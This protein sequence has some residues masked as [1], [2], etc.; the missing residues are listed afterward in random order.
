MPQ[1]SAAP[2]ESPSES[3]QGEAPEREAPEREAPSAAGALAHAIEEAAHLLPAQGPIGVFIHHNTLHAFQHLPFHEAV[4]AASAELETESYLSEADYRAAYARG[5]IDDSD[6]DAALAEHLAGDGATEDIDLA[7]PERELLHI[8]LRF[9]IP[10]ESAAGLRWQIDDLDALSHFRPEVDPPTRERLVQE[11]LRW[12]RR[13]EREGLSNLIDEPPHASLQSAPEAWVLRAMWTA[14]KS[15][16]SSRSSR[17]ALALADRVPS[18]RSHRDLLRAV[19]GADPASVV[20]ALLIRFCAAYLDQ[21][22]ASWAMP[23]REVGLYPAFRRTLRSGRWMM[24]QALEGVPA[25]LAEQARRGMS[26]SDVVLE[27]LELLGVSQANFTAYVARLLLEL[28]GWAGMIHRLET[29]PHEIEGGVAAPRLVDYL[30]ARLTCARVALAHHA[31]KELGYAGPLAE[32]PVFV[33]GL[34]LGERADRPARDE[35]A[36][37]LFN[38]L[39]LAGMSLADIEAIPPS[40][41][42]AIVDRLDDFDELTRRRVWHEAYEHHHRV[43]VLSAVRFAWKRARAAPPAPSRARYH[44]WFCIDDRE[45][46]MRRHLE[47]LGPL[48]ETTGLAGF[49]GVA[50][51]FRGLGSDRTASLCPVVVTPG[52]EIVEE[53]ELDHEQDQEA[54]EQRRELMARM[55]ASTRVGT[56][57]LFRSALLTPALGLLATFPMAMQVLFP[58]TTARLRAETTKWVNPTPRTR[59]RAIRDEQEDGSA[60][61]IGF[62]I[63]EAADRV[64]TTLENVGLV[65]DYPRVVALFGHGSTSVNNPHGSAYDCGACGGRHGS[66]NA[67]LFATLANDPRVREALREHGIDLPATTIFV[68]GYHDTATDAITLFDLD[69]VPE[70]HRADVAELRELLDVARR[71]NAHERCRRFASAPSDPTLDEALAHVEARAADLAQARPELGH[72]TNAVCLVG[73]REWSRGLFLDRR[74]FLVS[75]DPRIDLDG[76]ILERILAAVGPVG[77]GINLEYYFSCVDNDRYGSG[78][79][80]PHNLV[81]L[82]GVMDGPSSDLRTGLPRQMIE[83][84]E[85]VRLLTVVETTPERILEIAERQPE[86]RE[87]VINGWIQLAT[88]DPDSGLI[89]VFRPGFG[90][91]PLDAPERALPVV[92][93]SQAWYR[94]KHDFLPP[95]I[96]DPDARKSKRGTL[97]TKNKAPGGRAHAG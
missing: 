58:R 70:S 62:T 13:R 69:A 54:W 4:A 39:Q 97:R 1:Q 47:E 7:I 18:E 37:R 84:H 68:G 5:R 44:V 24:P 9:P 56:R 27:A 82:L 65:R 76:R 21:G 3:P 16:S 49:F 88:I 40:E 19:T 77:A 22:M 31:Q 94:G 34:D 53:P 73:R 45:E 81:G 80:L 17:S 91:T 78:T 23:E 64:R 79:K 25:L 6:L 51:D 55:T 96:V 29:H 71:R 14:C 36:F 8:A 30:A 66:P 41:R 52:H 12:L 61:P 95:A 26:A 33:R 87:L 2:S 59:L 48:V 75:Y 63:Q 50:I 43:E 32:L 83:I 46:S 86:V 35:A 10:V 85:P 15:V 20:N 89:H 28:P 92:P 90:F 38:V 93:S 74:A 42:Q 11:G 72:V 57:G 60:K 67:R